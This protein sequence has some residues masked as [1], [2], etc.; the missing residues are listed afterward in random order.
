MALSRVPE[1]GTEVAELL[2]TT[3]RGLRACKVRSFK[4]YLVFYLPIPDGIIIYHVI[5]GRRDYLKTIF[6]V[7]E[8]S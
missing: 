5:D 3:Y 8:D 1:G 7:S 2:N 6:E 4:N